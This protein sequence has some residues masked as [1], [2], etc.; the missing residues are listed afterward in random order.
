VTVKIVFIE[1]G[2]I[3]HTVEVTPGC[4]VMEAAVRNGVPGIA[5]ECG[6]SCACATCHVH[7]EPDWF[8]KLEPKSELES[9]TLEFSDDV[10]PNSRLCCQIRVTDELDGLRVNTLK[11]IL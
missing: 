7:V 9:A 2:G 5:A 3:E 10:R 1:P 6:G 8:Q 11:D 4:S